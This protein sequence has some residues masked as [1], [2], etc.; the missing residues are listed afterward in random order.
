VELLV[1]IAVGLLVVLAALGT[2]VYTNTTASAVTDTVRLNLQAQSVFEILARHVRQSATHTLTVPTTPEDP[3][4]P[5]NLNRIVTMDGVVTFQ[6]PLTITGPN[7][8]AIF[9][10]SSGDLE[11]RHSSNIAGT[12]PSFAPSA[13]LR[14]CLGSRPGINSLSVNIFTLDKKSRA[15][16]CS[17]G[18][19]P[20]PIAE[21]VEAFETRFGLRNTTTNTLQYRTSASMTTNDWPNVESIEV[22]LQLH[23]DRTNTPKPAVY[24]NCLGE[25]IT[26]TDGRLHRVFRR[27]YT[28]RP[29][30]GVGT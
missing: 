5:T 15:L 6:N 25:K 26:A 29:E 3:S 13:E 17:E 16:R 9:G 14:S 19:T 30:F 10:N 1:G 4:D 7:S 23:G 21:N 12:A 22:C 2:V 24:N 11:L 18:D 8:R 27:I 20:Q 28:V